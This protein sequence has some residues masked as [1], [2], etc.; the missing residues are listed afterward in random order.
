VPLAATGLVNSTSKSGVDR[1][2]DKEAEL[3]THDIDCSLSESRGRLFR[4]EA[5][6]QGS[7]LKKCLRRYKNRATV[8]ATRAVSTTRK[9]VC[10]RSNGRRVS[11]NRAQTHP[12]RLLGAFPAF[13]L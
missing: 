11:A 7:R 1:L 13:Q 10:G 9:G 3:A 2:Y 4:F 12:R 8:S 6:I 5:Q